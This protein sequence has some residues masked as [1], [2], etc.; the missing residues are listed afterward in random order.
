MPEILKNY[1]INDELLQIMKKLS[2]ILTFT[3]TRIRP[4]PLASVVPFSGSVILKKANVNSFFCN[5]VNLIIFTCDHIKGFLKT[6]KTL[7]TGPLDLLKTC[8]K[9]IGTLIFMEI[10][11]RYHSRNLKI[12]K[13]VFLKNVFIRSLKR[14]QKLC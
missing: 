1:Q 6:G 10:S 2:Y 9:M 7:E 8:A 11:S 3:S 13:K 5:L 12:N 14:G 4:T